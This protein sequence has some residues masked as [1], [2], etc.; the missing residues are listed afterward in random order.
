MVYAIVWW[1]NS[2]RNRSAGFLKKAD[3]LEEAKKIAFNYAWKSIEDEETEGVSGEVIG[4]YSNPYLDYTICSYVGG[5]SI[6]NTIY[7]V[8]EWFDGV[9]SKWDEYDID[10]D[11]TGWVPKYY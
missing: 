10:D 11:A 5:T 4:E 2:R 1:F 7:C 9:E 3:S 6:N 8:V